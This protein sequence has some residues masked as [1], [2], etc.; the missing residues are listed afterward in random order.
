VTTRVSPR[1]DPNDLGRALEGLTR[2]Q[3]YAIFKAVLDLMKDKAF[4]ARWD[5]AQR[6]ETA[7][8]R[9]ARRMALARRRVGLCD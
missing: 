8:E 3:R 4:L 7:E 5:R 1:T 9:Q 2:A 6:G